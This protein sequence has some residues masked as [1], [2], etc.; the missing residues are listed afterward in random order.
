MIICGLQLSTLY[1]WK[2]MVGRVVE[3]LKN[4]IGDKIYIL[5]TTYLRQI[6]E[7]PAK[8]LFFQQIYLYQEIIESSIYLGKDLRIP[9]A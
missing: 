3:T 1:F 7:K 6:I 8:A 4:K 9:A 5:T 2:S